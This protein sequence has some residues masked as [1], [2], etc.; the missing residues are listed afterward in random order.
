MRTVAISLLVGVGAIASATNLTGTLSVDNQFSFYISDDDSQLGTL[1]TSSTD[2]TNPTAINV[3]LKDGQDLFIHVVGFNDGGPDMFIGT[4]NL[5][6]TGFE[7]ANGGQMLN[8][9]L[10]NWKGNTTGFGNAMSTPLDYG[11]SGTS[12]WGSLNGI[13][14]GAH[15][16]WMDPQDGVNVNNYF[17]TK[18]TANAVPEPISASAL[19]VGF[20][21]LLARRRKRN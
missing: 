11:P 7:F 12:P 10:T 4:F 1:I 18:I 20:L 15:F 13:D 19:G 3:S 14:S 2:W 21:G 5:S 16:I 17:S 8:T 6:D 9:D